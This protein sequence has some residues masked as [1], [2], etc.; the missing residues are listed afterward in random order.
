MATPAVKAPVF[1]VRFRNPAATDLHLWIEPLGDQVTIPP[2]TTIE[3]HCTE[4][5]GYPNE[6]E[7]TNDGITVHGW[8]QSVF[9]LSD[10]G[11]LRSLWALPDE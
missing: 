1:R 7:M 6:F 9:A 5:L 2:S 11:E 4:Q 8:V 10:D 3:I